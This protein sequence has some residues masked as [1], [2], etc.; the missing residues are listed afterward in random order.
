MWGTRDQTQGL[1]HGMVLI[2]DKISFL[3]RKENIFLVF[4]LTYNIDLWCVVLMYGYVVHRDQKTVGF[5]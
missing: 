5:G 3:E 2:R 4:Q 1:V